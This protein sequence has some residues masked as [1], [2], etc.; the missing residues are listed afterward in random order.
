SFRDA[1]FRLLFI[2]PNKSRNEAKRNDGKISKNRKFVDGLGEL[3]SPWERRHLAC[4]RQAGSLRTQGQAR[5][6]RSQRCPQFLSIL[7]NAV[8][9]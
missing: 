1:P 2:S 9:L 7:N 4:A 3:Q 8:L 6:L 5:C